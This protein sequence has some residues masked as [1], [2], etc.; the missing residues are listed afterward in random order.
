MMK[1]QQ[2]KFEISYILLSLTVVAYIFYNMFLV[3]F[4]PS[5]NDFKGVLGI[6]MMDGN[7]KWLNGFYGPGYTVIYLF[8]GHD[9]L[10][11]GILY[12]GII[13]LSLMMSMYCI[14]KLD[15]LEWNTHSKYLLGIGSVL[16]HLFLFHM[17]GLNYLDGI[18]IFV[19]LCGMSLYFSSS[20]TSSYTS[21][22]VIGLMIMGSP[23]LFRTHGLIFSIITVVMFLVFSKVSIRH[24][25]QTV[26]ILLIPFFLY[27]G[28]FYIND[29]PYQNWQKINVYKFLYGVSWYNIDAILESSKYQNFNLLNTIIDDPSRVLHRVM[30]K[31]ESSFVRSFI[32]FVFV[33]PLVAYIFTKKRFFLAALIISILYFMVV[34]PGWKRGIYPLYLLT[35]IVVIHI[36]FLKKDTKYIWPILIVIL[37]LFTG[38]PVKNTLNKSLGKSHYVSYIKNDLEPTL[39][40][41]GVKD[42]KTVFTDDRNLYLDKFNFLEVNRF[43]GWRSM[44]PAVIDKE[45]RKMF[46]QSSFAQSNIRYIIAKKGKKKGYI[47]NKYVTNIKYKDKVSLQHHDIYILDSK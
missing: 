30:T 19:L 44:H 4:Y 10:S 1:I 36:Y 32:P 41:I 45:P 27:L 24:V 17:V 25:F 28:L 35:Y 37:I 20:Y 33:I 9:L 13:S 12:I 15:C 18:F 3:Q 7:D 42:L 38:E 16:M 39:I 26:L 14:K 46:E 29:I 43:T 31:V 23:I 5:L 8:I 2:Y 21:A 34:L 40:K 22:Q 6:A 47:N 11:W